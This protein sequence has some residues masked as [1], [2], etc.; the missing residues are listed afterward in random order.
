MSTSMKNDEDAIL[1][2]TT[3]YA[4]WW[5]NNVKTKKFNSFDWVIYKL[6]LFFFLYSILEE[7]FLKNIDFAAFVLHSCWHAVLHW[8]EQPHRKM[9]SC[10]VCVL[11]LYYRKL[12]AIQQCL[13]LFIVYFIRRLATNGFKKKKIVM[14]LIVECFMFHVFFFVWETGEAN[15]SAWVMVLLRFVVLTEEIIIMKHYSPCG[16]PYYSSAIKLN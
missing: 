8:I 6:L 3:I 15:H 14:N 1:R 2:W 13:P 16:E 11:S 12:Q 10:T 9:T 7:H 4:L 5:R